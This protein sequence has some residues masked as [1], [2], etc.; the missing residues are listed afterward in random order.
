V[1]LFV[2]PGGYKQFREL[3]GRR[4]DI[5]NFSFYNDMWNNILVTKRDDPGLL[6][7]DAQHK[8]GMAIIGARDDAQ[9]KKIAG[10]T[11]RRGDIL[12]L[13]ISEVEYLAQTH[14]LSSLNVYKSNGF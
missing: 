4:T 2:L 11:K 3:H 8:K 7:T 5:T 13:S 9:K 12:D 6:S 14:K 1:R 10:N